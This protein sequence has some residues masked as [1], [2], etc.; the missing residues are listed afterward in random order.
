M[1]KERWQNEDVAMQ[2]PFA[3]LAG[4]KTS[5]AAA[6]PEKKAESESVRKPEMPVVQS[7]RIERAQRGGKTVTVVTFRGEPSIEAKK[8]WLKT[9]KKSLG[10]GGAIEGETVILQGDQRESLK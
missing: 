2:N 7:A 6:E 1:A 4:L 10:V 8:L 9:M 3:S 5:P